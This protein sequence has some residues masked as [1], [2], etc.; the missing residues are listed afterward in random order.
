MAY[1]WWARIKRCMLL[2]ILK[3]NVYKCCSMYQSVTRANDVTFLTLI[4]IIS[5]IKFNVYHKNFN[6][7]LS[8]RA[9][10]SP[11][12]VQMKYN[13]CMH[14][15]VHIP[16]PLPLPDDNVCFHYLLISYAI[17]PQYKYNENLNC[18]K[19]LWR[20]WGTLAIRPAIRPSNCGNILVCISS[21]Q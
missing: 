1:I 7:L 13:S 19:N 18:N 9:H 16:Y 10:R 11:I 6:F 14:R 3:L 2:L 12:L 15:V 20:R 21:F 5:K 8:H 17:F 4:K